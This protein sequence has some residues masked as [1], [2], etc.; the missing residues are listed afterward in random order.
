MNR[1]LSLAVGSLWGALVV[2]SGVYEFRHIHGMFLFQDFHMYGVL[3]VAVPV[4]AIGLMLL[5]RMRVRSPDGRLTKISQRGRHPGN[6]PGGILFG[7]GW[8]ITGICPGTSLAQ[9]GTGSGKAII[10]LSAMLVGIAIYRP[11][12]ER[13]FRWKTE[14]C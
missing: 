5:K 10:A 13:F 6:L 2:K 14:S 4:A 9:L 11:I 7:I 3:G 12:H 1:V 8:A